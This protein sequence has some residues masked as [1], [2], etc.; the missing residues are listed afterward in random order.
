MPFA[1]VP[2]SSSQY[3]LVVVVLP[4]TFLH[5]ESQCSVKE[6]A[7]HLQTVEPLDALSHLVFKNSVIDTINLR[8]PSPPQVYQRTLIP[9]NRTWIV[10]S[11]WCLMLC[12]ALGLAILAILPDSL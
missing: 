3:Y 10:Q 11:T 6:W 9:L 2:F 4:F 12:Y 5:E 1:I 8:R 7:H